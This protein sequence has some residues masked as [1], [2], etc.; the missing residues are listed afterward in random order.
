[1]WKH[2][3]WAAVVANFLGVAKV[4]ILS[5]MS[6]HNGYELIAKDEKNG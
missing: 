1:V 2:A 6:T 5:A 4:I 3:I